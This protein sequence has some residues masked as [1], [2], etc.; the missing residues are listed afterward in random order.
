MCVQDLKVEMY[1]CNVTTELVILSVSCST[2]LIVSKIK[3]NGAIPVLTYNHNF[4]N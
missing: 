2:W 1:S 3:N 4:M